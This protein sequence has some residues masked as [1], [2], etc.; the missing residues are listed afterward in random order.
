[1][2]LVYNSTHELINDTR[3]IMGRET[4]STVGER[5]VKAVTDSIAELRAT[6]N[7]TVGKK[8]DLEFLPEYK[9]YIK[10]HANFVSTTRYSISSILKTDKPKSAVAF[11]LTVP[12][13]CAK[14]LENNLNEAGQNLVDFIGFGGPVNSDKYSEVFIE[15]WSVDLYKS[16]KAKFTV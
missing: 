7:S 9:C 13:E 2:V 14:Y 8:L 12:K 5:F 10:N 4:Y 15:I 1:M 11:R 6:I 3:Y 16:V